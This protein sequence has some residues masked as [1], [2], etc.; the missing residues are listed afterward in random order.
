MDAQQTPPCVQPAEDRRDRT[1]SE[2]P[3]VD[4]ERLPLLAAYADDRLSVQAAEELVRLAED[5]SIPE[6]AGEDLPKAD[7]AALLRKIQQAQPV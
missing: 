5:A 3:V 7:K 6:H 4:R 2:E 1:P